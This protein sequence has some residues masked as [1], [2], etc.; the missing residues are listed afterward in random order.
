MKVVAPGAGKPADPTEKTGVFWHGK[1]IQRMGN[2]P[3]KIDE[4]SG[5]M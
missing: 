4:H 2:S 3:Q 5:F 1:I